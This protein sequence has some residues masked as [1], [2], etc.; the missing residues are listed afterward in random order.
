MAQVRQWIGSFLKRHKAR[1]DPRDWPSAEDAED[2]REYL[3]TWITAFATRE[4]AEGE[5]D[6][7]SRLL[8]PTPP[9]FRREHLPMVLSMIESLRQQRGTQPAAS[10]RELARD[11]ARDCP[12]CG[13]EGLATAWAAHPDAAF[14]I[15]ETVAAYC[16]CAH[17][18]FI[19]RSHAD[20][21]PAMIRRI[22]DFGA[23]L[24]GEARGWLA[25]PPGR[26]ELGVANERADEFIDEAPAPTRTQVAEMF[27]AP[28]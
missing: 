19:K 20:K 1:F 10:T 6:E 25:H 5:A 3:L 21:E 17:G 26:Q 23:V 22:P 8:G 27:Q 28:H 12:Y 18:R 7:A 24:D 15:S 4:I 2:Y 13:S 14:K 11:A 9:N 16:V